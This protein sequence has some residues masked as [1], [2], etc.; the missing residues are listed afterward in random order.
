MLEGI[1]AAKQAENGLKGLAV[2]CS[3][4]VNVYLN[5]VGAYMPVTL[6]IEKP[7]VAEHIHPLCRG[8]ADLTFITPGE[9]HVWEYKNGRSVVEAFENWQCICAVP[10]N[11]P[12]SWTVVIHVCQ[13]RAYHPQGP[14]REWRVPPGDL[15]AYFNILRAAANEAAGKDP[16]V[17][18]GPH[19]W[20]CNAR[21]ACPAAGKAASLFADYAESA[22]PHDLTPDQIGQEIKLLRYATSAIKYRLTALEAQAEAM[23]GVPGYALDSGVGKL[24]WSQGDKEIAALAKGF[25]VNLY[26][27]PELLTPTQVR[28]QKKLPP[29]ILAAFTKR[30]PG[31]RHLIEADKGLAA[32]AF[33]K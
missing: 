3:D 8:I 11:L 31:A 1:E 27:P 7:M 4:A 6:N 14:V 32:R 5:A 22:V 2:E 10:D 19:C 20:G 24:V 13:P 12:L 21:R 26:K 28:D 25:G 9:F 15:R 23:G 18:A 17:K 33:K 29:D 16:R 30:N